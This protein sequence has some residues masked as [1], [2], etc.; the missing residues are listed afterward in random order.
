ME[1]GGHGRPFLLKKG[2]STAFF[3]PCG[4]PIE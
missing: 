2:G 4:L 1:K 3:I